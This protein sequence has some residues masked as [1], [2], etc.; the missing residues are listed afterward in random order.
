MVCMRWSWQA[1]RGS[2][3]PSPC[4][5]G[6]PWLLCRCAVLCAQGALLHASTFQATETCAQ[7]V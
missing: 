3:G 2:V 7:Y 4:P 1:Q 6:A 5:I